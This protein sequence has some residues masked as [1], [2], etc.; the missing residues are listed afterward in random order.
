MDVVFFHNLYDTL[1]N[2]V[3]ISPE[4]SMNDLFLSHA[5]LRRMIKPHCVMMC[6]TEQH[7]V[8]RVVQR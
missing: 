8:E 5:G 2:K 1:N 6:W 4:K 3:E 7:A